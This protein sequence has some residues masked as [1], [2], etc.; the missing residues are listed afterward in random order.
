[1]KRLLV[2]TLLLLS[3]CNTSFC[4]NNA[5]NRHKQN[6]R[7][8]RPQR[9]SHNNI[10]ESLVILGGLG[11]GAVGTIITLY[12]LVHAEPSLCK[13]MSGG[14]Q[15][16]CG[17]MFDLPMALG[18]WGVGTAVGIVAGAV[19]TTRLCLEPCTKHTQRKKIKN[20][21]KADKNALR[22]REKKERRINKRS[23]NNTRSRNNFHRN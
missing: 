11:G 8:S 10:K 6:N 19:I 3:L 9:N 15:G 20:L 21:I 5:H 14:A 22:Y 4:M 18:L 23:Y 7:G 17:L 1:M 12:I 2:S 16:L 13:E